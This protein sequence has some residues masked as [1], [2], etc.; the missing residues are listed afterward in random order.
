[1]VE[2]IKHAFA[3]GPGA[4]EHL[5]EAVQS[6]HWLIK[7]HEIEQEPDQFTGGHGAGHHGF[8]AEPQHEHGAERSKKT[9]GRIIIG[10]RAHDAEIALAQ[11][12]GAVGKPRVLVI[13]PAVSLDLP[14]ALQVIH[15]Q[16]VHGTGSL[17]LFA[18]T[19]MGS[20]RVPQGASGQKRQWGQRHRGKG[21]VRVKQ[22][23]ADAADAEDGDGALFGA[24]NQHAFNV[25]DVLDHPRH[26]VATGAFVE[27]TDRQTLQLGKHITPHVVDDVLLKM[28]VDA[29]AQ[30]VEQVPQQERQRHGADGPAELGGAA[31]LLDDAVDNVFGELGIGERAEKR[32]HGAADGGQREALVRQ[33]IGP[34]APEDFAGGAFA[35]LKGGIVAG[36]PV[37]CHGREEYGR[38]R[39][40]RANAP[41]NRHAIF[42]PVPGVGAFAVGDEELLA[43]GTVVVPAGP[44]TFRPA[45]DKEALRVHLPLEIHAL[46]AASVWPAFL[47]EIGQAI[48]EID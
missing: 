24:V 17:A 18:I 3:G 20:E 10:P 37:V 25:V 1:M 13:L 39:W 36:Q 35:R 21:G 22:N 34:H 8:A 19:P 16:R 45:I 9:H 40:R 43:L 2:D 14:D 15:E 5:V 44:A 7:E 42:V 41:L 4:L 47:S 48:E 31:I 12:L 38:A 28:I 33:Q 6:G 29:D 32:Q 30:A 11:S 23:A 27:V 46:G 26:Q